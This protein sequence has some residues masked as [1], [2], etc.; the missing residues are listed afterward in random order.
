VFF[1]FF[2]FFSSNNNID[3]NRIVHDLFYDALGNKVT[4]YT[5]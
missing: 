3:L 4:E 2:F 5:D 1:F